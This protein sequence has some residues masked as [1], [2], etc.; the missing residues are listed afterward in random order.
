MKIIFMGT[1]E[2]SVPVLEALATVHEVVAS[3]ASR[4]ARR[5]G[6]RPTAPARCRRGPRL[7]ACRCAT[8]SR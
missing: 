7:W 3:T 6:A 1:P 2:F 8:R 5:G 4:R